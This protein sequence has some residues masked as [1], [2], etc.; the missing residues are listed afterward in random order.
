MADGS[1]RPGS[2]ADGVRQCPPRR[3]P[4]SPRPALS[5]AGGEPAAL[6][7]EVGLAGRLSRRGGVADAAEPRGEGPQPPRR[8]QR[9]GVH[10]GG[11]RVLRQEGGPGGVPES[12][13]THVPTPSPAGRSGRPSSTWGPSWPSSLP[14]RGS[15][16]GSTALERRVVRGANSFHHSVVAAVDMHETAH[17]AAA[18]TAAGQGTAPPAAQPRDGLTRR[19]TSL[20][21]PSTGGWARLWEWPR[22][23]QIVLFFV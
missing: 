23:S 2:V 22:C 13:A 20:T 5:P 19:V 15:G 9:R 14:P 10:G 11:R 3:P 12:P 7:S 21:V 4:A 16:G 18:W 17:Q 8:R 1:V 6:G